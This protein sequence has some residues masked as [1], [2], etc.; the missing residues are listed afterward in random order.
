MYVPFSGL[1]GM[2]ASVST[3]SSKPVM[4]DVCCVTRNSSSSMDVCQKETKACDGARRG[5]LQSESSEQV[6]KYGSSYGRVFES[7]LTSKR[8]Y[9]RRMRS[10]NG[11]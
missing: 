5:R 10:C 9:A 11:A 7:G 3:V 1:T 2:V 8:R 6:K 4:E